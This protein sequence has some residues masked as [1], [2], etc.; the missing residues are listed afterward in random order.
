MLDD[1]AVPDDVDDADE[2]TAEGLAS[3]ERTV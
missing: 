1:V 2:G 3:A